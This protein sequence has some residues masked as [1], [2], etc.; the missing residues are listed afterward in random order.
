MSER[1]TLLQKIQMYHFAVYDVLL[2]LDNHPQNASALD[3][4]RKS[5]QLLDQAV[6]EFEEKYGPMTP[7]V[8]EDDKVWRWIEDPWPWEGEDN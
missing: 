2:F 7:A 3:Y 1:Q 5:R 8:Q 6:T 4:F